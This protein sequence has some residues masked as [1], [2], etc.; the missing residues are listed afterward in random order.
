MYIGQL[1]L[2]QTIQ[3]LKVS[4]M[5]S[6][7]NKFEMQDLF[8]SGHSS[9]VNN[10]LFIQQL[11]S[12][13]SV[14]EGIVGDINKVHILVREAW[15]LRG[16]NKPLLAFKKGKDLFYWDRSEKASWSSFTKS[17]LF[18]WNPMI[19][20]LTSFQIV[21]KFTYSWRFLWLSLL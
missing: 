6:R 12:V 20:F 21:V 7:L 13:L 15:C 3:V 8:F 4:L 19:H 10:S 11:C 9:F 14:N 17:V 16:V 18:P 1:T 2:R 5:V